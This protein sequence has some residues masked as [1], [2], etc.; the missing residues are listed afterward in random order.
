MKKELQEKFE[1]LRRWMI[2]K[3]KKFGIIV[4]VSDSGER[5]TICSALDA[6]LLHEPT[7][8]MQLVYRIK[9]YC[10]NGYRLRSEYFD[11]V[12]NN[13]LVKRIDFFSPMHA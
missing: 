11:F 2:S 13:K 6:H 3:L 4:V 7:R 8:F 12:D 9:A 10:E 5:K 1:A